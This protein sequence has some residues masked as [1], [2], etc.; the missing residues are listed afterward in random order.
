MSCRHYTHA[1]RVLLRGAAC[2]IQ[3]RTAASGRWWRAALRRDAILSHGARGG[4]GQMRYGQTG[5]KAIVLGGAAASGA[6]R[7]HGRSARTSAATSASWEHRTPL[8]RP[9]AR[10]ARDEGRRAEISRAPH[11]EAA[12]VCRRGAGYRGFGFTPSGWPGALEGGESPASD[13]RAEL[14]SGGLRCPR[15]PRSDRRRGAGAAR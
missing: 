8:A 3:R 4:T 2:D 6:V 12:R 7:V 13:R 10:T 11:R 15:E 14:P 5:L 9:A 1:G